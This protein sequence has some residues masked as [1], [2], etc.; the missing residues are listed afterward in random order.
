MVLP[1][2]V[3]VVFHMKSPY[4]LMVS[5][6]AMSVLISCLYFYIEYLIRTQPEASR[7]PP[8]VPHTPP[9]VPHTPPEVPHTGSSGQNDM[10]GPLLG[11]P[12]SQGETRRE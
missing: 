1:A 11:P 8:E 9:E 2:L 10:T 7:T 6:F 12:D 5:L 4:T 3:G